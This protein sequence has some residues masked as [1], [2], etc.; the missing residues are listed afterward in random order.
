MFIC[1]TMPFHS[2]RW[3]SYSKYSIFEVLKIQLVATS[4]AMLIESGYVIANHR[5]FTDFALDPFL[6]DAAVIGRRAA[7][8]GVFWN[9]LIGYLDNRII[10][11]VRGKETRSELFRRVKQH[12][13]RKQRILFFPEGSRMSYTHLASSED[14][15][16]HLKYGLL[17]EIYLDKIYPVQIQI[18]SN[19]ETVFNEKTIHFQP[20]V[21]VKTHR[22]I[23]IDPKDYDTE[24]KFYDAIAS[25]WYNAW[26]KTHT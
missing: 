26:V 2:M 7:F 13:S 9:S 1:M 15:K 20:G 3:Y 5:S 18:S 25:E 6:A 4:D 21:L 24:S 17:K 8:I 22:S 11:F 12:F 10:W 16:T 23:A 19:K 14:V